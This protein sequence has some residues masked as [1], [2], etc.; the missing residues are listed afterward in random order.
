[1]PTAQFNVT[2]LVHETER[3]PSDPLP[4]STTGSYPALEI[5]Y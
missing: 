4:T 1:M 5:A 2:T 3:L